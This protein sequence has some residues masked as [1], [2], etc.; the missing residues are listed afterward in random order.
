MAKPESVG[1]SWAVIVVAALAVIIGACEGDKPDSPAKTTTSSVAQPGARRRME[2]AKPAEGPTHVE[3]TTPSASLKV[4]K[5]VIATLTEGEC[6][7][8]L[9]SQGKWFQISADGRKGWVHAKDVTPYG[10]RYHAS[11]AR[12]VME[13][14]PSAEDEDVRYT[15]LRQWKP[16]RR[17]RGLG[18]D[19]LLE[20]EVDEG[21]LVQFVKRFAAGHNPVVIRV[22]TSREAYADKDAVT[23]AFRTG[24]LIFY[25]KNGTGSGAYRGLDEIRWMQEVGKFSSRFGQKTKF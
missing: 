4:G 3:I 10:G 2:R 16:M 25:V 1:A 15:I 23:P 9:E 13:V 19:V 24:F 14:R 5:K 6:Y 12:P 7:R 22:F 21:Q 17:A 18:A 11:P 8:I 20:Q